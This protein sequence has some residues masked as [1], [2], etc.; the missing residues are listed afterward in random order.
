MLSVVVYLLFCLLSLWI[1][2]SPGR[3]TLDLYSM[4]FGGELIIDSKEVG[5]N[6]T[7]HKW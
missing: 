7:Q 6:Y 1:T 2:L 4:E 5:G 3:H